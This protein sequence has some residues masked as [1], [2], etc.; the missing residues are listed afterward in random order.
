[1]ATYYSDLVN[2]R[3]CVYRAF[4]IDGQLLY[5]GIS[6]NLSGRLDKHRRSAWWPEVD[7]IVVEWFDGREAAKVAEREAILTEEPIYNVAGRG[8]MPRIR[9]VN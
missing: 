4:D 8:H 5:V 9:E 7:E 6:M 1:M 2:R 3:T